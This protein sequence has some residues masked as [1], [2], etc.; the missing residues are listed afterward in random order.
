MGEH[1]PGGGALAALSSKRTS[2]PQLAA[3]EPYSLAVAPDFPLIELIVL[4]TS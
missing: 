2:L 1:G 4:E 3:Q